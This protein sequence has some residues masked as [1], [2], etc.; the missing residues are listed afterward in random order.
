MTEYTFL[1]RGKVVTLSLDSDNPFHD[2]LA[3]QL[4]NRQSQRLRVLS[5]ALD[6]RKRLNYIIEQMQNDGSADLVPAS[7][8]TILNQEL[9][10]YD[11]LTWFIDTL[12]DAVLREGARV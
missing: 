3:Q 6:S 12:T 7:T 10:T 8:S 5:A 1:H 11:R 9:A 2:A 4:A